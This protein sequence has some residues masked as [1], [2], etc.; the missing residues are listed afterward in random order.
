MSMAD[1]VLGIWTS[2]GMTI[3]VI[4]PRRCICKIPWLKGIS[5]LDREFPSRN[6]RKSEESR[7]RIAV[8]QE[9]EATSSLKDFI[10]PK[11]ITR[12][13]FSDYEELDLV[14]A[15]ELKWCYD[16]AYLICEIT[17]R[18]AV[19]SKRA[20][21]ACTERKTEECF[22]RKTIRWLGL[23]QEETLV[24]F[25]ACT[26]RETVRTTWNEVE[27]REKFS[28][29][30]SIRFSTESEETDWRKS[31]NSMKASSSTEAQNSLSI[32]GKMK[33]IVVCLSTSSRVSWL[34][35][36]KHMPFLAIVANAD[37]LMVKGNSARGREKKVL[38][39]QLLFWKKKNVQGCVS[40][41]SDPMNSTLQKSCLAQ[42]WIRERKGQSGGI[43]QN[44]E[45]H[46]RNPCAPVF[47]E[48][49]PEETLR[50]A[51]CT[52]KVAW[53][54]AR[55]YASSS[56]TL[57]YVLV[58]APETQKIVCLLCIRELQCTTL[59]KEMRNGN[60]EKVQ[61]PISD[62]PQTG[63]VQINE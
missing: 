6:L 61:Q 54:L 43:I 57:N 17:E 39:D 55:K 32:A 48:Q 3:F 62:L 47:D 22:Q 46:E 53:N 16:I 19:T 13:Y 21:N 8:D 41:N 38:D 18:G 37:M 7:A 60:F 42:N 33:N 24:V 35:V 29:R 34:Q 10:N 26:P 45:H 58:K 44:G 36:W 28:P 11:S 9:I 30:A 15:A 14:M 27:I 12:K 51:D 4:S 2:S 52:S 59:C 1:H 20:K 31:L 63:A 25:Y 40:Q 5:K 23:V 49:P 50:Q 56:R